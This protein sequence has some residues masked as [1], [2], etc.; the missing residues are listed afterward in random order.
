MKNATGAEVTFEVTL[1]RDGA[2]LL[3]LEVDPFPERYVPIVL[4]GLTA[5]HAAE[6]IAL[7]LAFER[8]RADAMWSDDATDREPSAADPGRRRLPPGG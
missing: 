1:T 8:R 4:T 7:E 2:I 6:C 3:G 5:A